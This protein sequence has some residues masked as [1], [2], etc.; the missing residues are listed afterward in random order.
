MSDTWSNN[1][2]GKSRGSRSALPTTEPWAYF[3]CRPQVRSGFG[4]VGF[5]S[6]SNRT[7]LSATRSSAISRTREKF[8]ARSFGP[9]ILLC[10]NRPAKCGGDSPPSCHLWWVLLSLIVEVCY[11]QCDFNV[12]LKVWLI[13][14]STLND[15]ISLR[16]F[17]FCI[18]VVS[19][20][21]R[22]LFL[23]LHRVLQ[24]PPQQL[25]FLKYK[26]KDFALENVMTVYKLYLLFL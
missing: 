12:L 10:R 11:W 17:N 7:R 4:F 16:L 15:N 6:I 20:Q 18:D 3:M 23:N 21:Q 9:S 2:K 8:G 13:P 19:V 26:I 22:N 24:N 5:V 25:S 1:R 14:F